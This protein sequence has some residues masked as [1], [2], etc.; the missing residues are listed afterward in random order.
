MS[1]EALFRLET[2]YHKLES[3][4]LAIEHDPVSGFNYRERF[5]SDGDLIIR[6]NE[7]ANLTDI[8]RMV[9]RLPLQRPNA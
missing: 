3:E 5:D 4:N 8:S 1:G 2:I 7:H 6:P 9:W